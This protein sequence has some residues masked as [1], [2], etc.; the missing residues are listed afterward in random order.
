MNTTLT[1]VLTLVLQLASGLGVIALLRPRITRRVA[2]PSAV[3]IGMFLHTVVLF[4]FAL[5]SVELTRSVG[6]ITAVIAAVLPHLAWPR[7]SSAY[8]QW[9]RMPQWTLSLSDIVTLGFASYLAYAAFW[10]AS[11]WPVTPFDA[12]VGIDLVAKT[13]VED[14]TLVNRVFTDPFLSQHLSN[15]PFYAPFAMLLQVIYRLIG[16]TSGQIWVPIVA[17]C[18]MWITWAEL[19]RTLHHMLANVLWLLLL[20]TPEM[21]GYTYLVQTDYLNAAM[22]VPGVLLL[23]R[24]VREDDR[25]SMWLSTVFFAAACWSR[26]D[27]IILVEL[28]LVASL[29]LVA[30][31]TSWKNAIQTFA[32]QSAVMGVVF[33]VWHVLFFNAYLP[34]R[35]STSDQLLGFDVARAVDVATSLFTNVIA[36]VDYWGWLFI[37]APLVIII[38][39]VRSRKLEPAV[40]LVWLGVLVLGFIVIGTIFSAAIVEQTL[41]RGIFKVIPLVV[42]A[43]AGTQLMQTASR[44]L[45]KWEAGR[46][47]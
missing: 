35:P 44:S 13:A 25:G 6:M 32:V 5:A 23:W 34:V 10:A 3:L 20:L 30:R 19:R 28:G 24:A 39:T 43:M 15:Q 8:T 29:P 38:N 31:A 11:Y 7:V 37:L 4:L 9:V 27:A 26:T 17:V 33:A 40:P 46:T 18:F 21:L 42:I 22:F 14:G 2:L 41:R 45:T 12:V 16:F 47:S 1:L 36:D